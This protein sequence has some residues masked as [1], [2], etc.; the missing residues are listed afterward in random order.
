MQPQF[1]I[2]NNGHQIAPAL[3]P[4]CGPVEARLSYAVV[5]RADPVHYVHDNALEC[6]ECF[7]VLAIETRQGW[8]MVA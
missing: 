1:D 2:D 3:C 7:K 5:R 4:S 6:P 8:E